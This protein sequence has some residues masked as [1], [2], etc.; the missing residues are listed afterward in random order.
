MT[1]PNKLWIGADPGGIGNFGAAIL[2][3]DGS[4]QTF[5]VD[6]ADDAIK[7]ITEHVK[8]MPAGVGVDAPLWWSSGR[9]GERQAD[10]WIRAK[11]NLPGGQVQTLNSLRGA[12]LI[13][14]IMFVQRLRQLY[15]EV[16]VTETHPKAV[17]TALRV[18]AWDDFSARYAVAGEI[19]SQHEFDAITSAVAAREGFD[20]RWKHDLS[21][22]RTASEQ[23]PKQFW[24]APIHYF[25]PE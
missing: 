10:R 12:A 25:W 21:L 24:L 9:S 5:C 16:R 8:S 17:R 15:P 18:P 4:T 23:D 20:G 13:Q 7:V 3:T 6:S 14:G 22:N 1:S 11:Y 19:G 2:N